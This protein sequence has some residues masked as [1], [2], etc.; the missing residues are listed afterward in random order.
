MQNICVFDIETIP[1]SVSV[2]RLKGVDAAALSEVEQVELAKLHR[3]GAVGND[4]MRHHLHRVVAISACVYINGKHKVASLAAVDDDEKT[5]IE[6]FFKLIDHCKPV[7][8]SWN[9]NGFDLPVLH[10]RS[11]F[12]GICAPTYWDVGHFDSNNKWS[13]YLAR[14]QWRHIDLMDVVAGYQARTVAP[15]DEVA[16]LCGFPGKLATD[17][18]AVLDLYQA[19]KVEAIRDY[20]ETDVLNTYL[21]YLRFE[22]M[23]GLLLGHQYEERMAALKKYLQQ[24][25]KTHFNEFLSAWEAAKSIGQS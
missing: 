21:L 12:Y 25:N 14:F 2:C 15:L 17:G 3:R 19:D 1:D 4:F 7:L 10:Y 6:R 9:G 20:C 16:K 18:S 23:R 11:L 22:L 8:V 13:N 5:I 24:Q